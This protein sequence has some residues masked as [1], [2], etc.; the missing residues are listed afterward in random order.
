MPESFL[1]SWE[2]DAMDFIDSMDAWLNRRQTFVG[3]GRAGSEDDDDP[4]LGRSKFK[5]TIQ[6]SSK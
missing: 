1:L 2:V 6:M 4:S 5:K 3:K